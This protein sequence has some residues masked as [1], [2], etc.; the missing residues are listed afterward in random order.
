MADEAITTAVDL[1]GDPDE[2]DEALE[3]LDEG[4]ALRLLGEFKDAV[5]A[6]KDVLAKAEGV[7]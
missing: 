2:I 1:G 6:Y 3:L 5:S 7:L 4:D